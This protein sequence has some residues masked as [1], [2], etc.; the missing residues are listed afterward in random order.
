L[1]PVAAMVG[2]L[3]VLP[4]AC[5][6]TTVISIPAATS[7]NNSTLTYTGPLDGGFFS[8]FTFTT[9]TYT[10]ALPTQGADGVI[11]SQT[12]IIM[13]IPVDTPISLPAVVTTAVTSVPDPFPVSTTPNSP[14]TTGSQVCS[15]NF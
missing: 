3:S 12:Y 13:G 15:F 2:P 14:G 11:D 5:T 1:A 4:S 9:T 6:I 10:T 8:P 7:V